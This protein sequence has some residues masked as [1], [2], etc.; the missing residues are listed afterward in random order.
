MLRKK[1]FLP[2][3]FA[4]FSLACNATNQIFQVTQTPVPA[5]AEIV[6]V[7][8]SPQDTATNEPT[9]TEA[10]TLA[11]TDTSAPTAVA[12]ATVDPYT[13]TLE[14]MVG[15]AGALTNISQYFNPVGAPLTTWRNVPIMPQATAGQEFNANI[16]SYV[17]VTTL[18]QA[19]QFYTSKAA[20][21]GLINSPGTGYAGTG[22]RAYHDVGFI[23]YGLTIELTS[24]DNN[25]GHVIV[26][27]SKFP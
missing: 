11:P 17:A 25:T 18:S 26:V 16:Y 6:T 7:T 9:V 27:I 14:A 10:P 12:T 22:S 1:K 5:Q 15:S 4:L 23:S 24:Y 8:A 21:L 2:V 3:L 19:K 13:A 20:S